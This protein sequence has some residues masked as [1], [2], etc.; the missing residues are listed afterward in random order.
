VGT[1][2]RRS[3]LPDNQPPHVSGHRRAASSG[4]ADE[5][6]LGPAL[7]E[8]GRLADRVAAGDILASHE[9]HEIDL[10]YAGASR[11]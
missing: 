11:I 8:L 3:R 2:H 5:E 4:R 10:A 9:L 7:T 1:G 6:R